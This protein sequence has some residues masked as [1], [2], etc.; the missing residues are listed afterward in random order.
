MERGL[1]ALH[2]DGVIRRGVEDEAEVG[3]KL[4]AADCSGLLLSERELA[5]HHG[6][7]EGLCVTG[8]IGV[9]PDEGIFPFEFLDRV[10]ALPLDDRN[11]KS[12]DGIGPSRECLDRVFQ[13]EGYLA[14]RDAVARVYHPDDASPHVAIQ[15]RAGENEVVADRGFCVDRQVDDDFV[16]RG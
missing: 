11:L 5:C 14:V 16:G 15:T 10:G 12:L 2:V 3:K 1:S 9:V 7:S 8:G 6:S 4:A 13:G